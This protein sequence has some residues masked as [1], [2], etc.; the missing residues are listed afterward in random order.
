MK[1]SPILVLISLFTICLSCGPDKNNETEVISTDNASSEQ[2]VVKYVAPVVVDSVKTTV[3]SVTPVQDGNRFPVSKKK[4]IKDGTI[5]VKTKDLS[6]SKKAID[7]LVKTKN[8]YYM[9]EEFSTDDHSIS[10]SL[11]IRIPTD[12]FENFLSGIEN[13][14][15]EIINKSIQARDVTEEFTDIETRLTTKR[16]YLKRYRELLS[17]AKTVKD[18]LE[19]EGNIRAIQ[20]EI[21]SR[22]GR[23]NYL[24]DQVA[25][26][27]LDVYLFKDKEYLYKPQEQSKFSE[28]VKKS[29]RKGW[30]S[31]VNFVIGT[32]SAWPQILL[33]IMSFL[34]I[35]RVIRKRKINQ[36]K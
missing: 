6:A 16:E 34:I 22:Q 21:D 9:T 1:R 36:I 2:T 19:I 24:S 5:S 4:I 25:Y 27:T 15:D 20:E 23:L 35:K 28:R 26:S 33:I 10:Y 30:N 11:K 32:I 13:G 18:I 17:T 12:S 8:A 29:L 3:E 14:N 7:E 31:I